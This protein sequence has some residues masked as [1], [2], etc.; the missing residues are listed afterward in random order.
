MELDGACGAVDGVLEDRRQEQ[1]TVF[2]SVSAHD[3]VLVNWQL[4][5]EKR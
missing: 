1:R 4:L 2:G 5:E 3:I